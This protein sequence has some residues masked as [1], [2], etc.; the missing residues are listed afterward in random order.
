M[1]RRTLTASPSNF[2]TSGYSTNNST[3]LGFD[4]SLR[5]ITTWLQI[6]GIQPPLISSVNSNSCCNRFVVLIPIAVMFFLLNV[7]CNAF[8]L[9]QINW[10]ASKK[11]ISSST[12]NWNSIINEINFSFLTLATHSALLFVSYFMAW[13]S[14]TEVLQRLEQGHQFDSSN[15]KK[16]RSIC[17]AGSCFMCIVILY[18]Y[19]YFNNFYELFRLVL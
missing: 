9:G 19:I 2:I 11:N 8:A 7:G 6:F 15:Y 17:I 1:G 12:R 5:P 13:K 14:L 3:L 10:N 4:W 16:F 18:P